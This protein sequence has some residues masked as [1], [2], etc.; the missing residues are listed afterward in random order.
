MPSPAVWEG[1]T[2][3]TVLLWKR[4][5]E[6]FGCPGRDVR[7]ASVVEAEASHP[8]SVGSASEAGGSDASTGNESGLGG[9]RIRAD[10]MEQPRAS[11]RPDASVAGKKY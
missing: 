6:S 2:C 3:H 5:G 8:S 4:R 1:G 7:R 11:K 10:G 9:V